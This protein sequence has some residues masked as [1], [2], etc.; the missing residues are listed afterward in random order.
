MRFRDLKARPKILV[1]TLSPLILLILLAG[2]AYYS[3]DTIIETD[4]AVDRTNT[5]LSN[6]AAIVRSAVDMETGM[7]GYLLSGKDEFLEPYHDGEKKTFNGIV[8]LQK[9][10]EDNTMQVKRQDEAQDILRQWRKN[11]A[12]PNITLHQQIGGAKTM[13]HMARLVGEAKGKV[14][15]D[16][17]RA[18]IKTFI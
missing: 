3:I 18:Q 16:K 2:V 7:R 11:V 1:G 6:A 9:L 15:F 12:Q 10:V 14:F 17:F 5:V 8:T 13:N 4:R